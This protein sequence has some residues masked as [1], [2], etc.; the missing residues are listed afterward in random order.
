M[1][2]CLVT[3]LSG[4]SSNTQLLRIGEMRI[5]FKKATVPTDSTQGFGLEVNKS[6][7]LEIIGDGYFTDKTLSVNKGTSH[8]ITPESPDFF[9]SDNTSEVSVLNKYN[10]TAL[11]SYY[12]GQ[13][14]AIVG[15]CKGFSIS[16]IKYSTALTSLSLSSTQITGNID[17]LKNLTVLNDLNLSSTQVT[18]SI[19]NLKNLT[20]LTYLNLSSTQIT[21][22]I[23]NLKNLTALTYLN[24]SSTQVTGSIDNLKNLTAL[25]SLSLSGTQITGNIDNLKNLTA[26]TSLVIARA[27]L[28][29]DL[30]LLPPKCIF[31]SFENNTNTVFTWSTRPSSSLIVSIIGN[32][33]L[34]N[35][36]KML[37]DQSQCQVGDISVS[38]VIS[39]V[40][41]RTSASD[42]A[43][44]TLQS[45]GYTVTIIPE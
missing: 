35:I 36:D 30:A 11:R 33:K 16:N 29:G 28:N 14:S 3:K 7:K 32:V 45:K 26:L 39:V 12:S 17:N 31:A 8:I 18:G 34:S 23:D 4:S 19:D 9:V 24:L 43:V 10:I 6:V 13:S 22:N 42:T 21:G 20:A 27:S 41:T 1:N 5:N 40:G 25:T 44:S 2:K 15:L 38:S 37:Q